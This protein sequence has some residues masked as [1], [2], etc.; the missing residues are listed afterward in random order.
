MGVGIASE[1]NTFKGTGYAYIETVDK[2]RIGDPDM[3]LP[4]GKILQSY[5][6]VIRTQSGNI[7]YAGR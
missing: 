2:K 3:T 4:S 6:E 1:N 7:R 5:P